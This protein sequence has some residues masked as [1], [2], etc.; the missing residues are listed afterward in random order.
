M[1]SASGINK[2][3]LHRNITNGHSKRKSSVVRA[4][5]TDDN[6]IQIL[7]HVLG[8]LKLQPPKTSMFSMICYTKSIWTK[9][10]LT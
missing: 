6:E 3:T 8:S 10:G 1:T 9:N 4:P 7:E 5:L 2:S